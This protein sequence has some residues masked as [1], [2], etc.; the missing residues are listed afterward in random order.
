MC[1]CGPRSRRSEPGFL[2]G[3]ISD[4]F[5][6]G[7]VVDP[8]E[9]RMPSVAQKGQRPSR[10]PKTSRLLFRGR[11]LPAIMASSEGGERK[12]QYMQ[13]YGRNFDNVD[14]CTL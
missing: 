6:N 9:G 4:Q 5:Q 12:A 10:P 2:W 7:P 3:R 13:F 11:Q 1:V 14:M 8:G